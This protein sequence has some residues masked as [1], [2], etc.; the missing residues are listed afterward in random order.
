MTTSKDDCGQCTLPVTGKDKGIQCEVCVTWFHAKCQNV[1]EDSYKILL[2]D[3]SLHWYCKGCERGV[4]KIL[5]TLSGLQNKQNKMDEDIKSI[6][7]DLIDI[8]EKLITVS[9]NSAEINKELKKL[10]AKF[11]RN[12]MDFNGEIQKLYAKFESNVDEKMK[13][14]NFQQ[15]T[16][17]KEVVN[18]QIQD[19]FNEVTSKITSVTSK[20]DEVRSIAIE[21]RDREN[22]A[23]NIIMYNVKESSGTSREERWQDD[24]KFCLELFNRVLKVQIRHS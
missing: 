23:C 18:E 2:K 7:N 21:E 8:R 1:P 9:N 3:K 19:Q 16:K 13:Q 22:R 12:A 24:K 11:E 10:D 4:S 5:E 6:A 14:Q 20:L 17:L 15:T